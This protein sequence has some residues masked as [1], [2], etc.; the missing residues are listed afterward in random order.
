MNQRP[1]PQPS[2]P[3]GTR[4]LDVDISP[5]SV[6]LLSLLHDVTSARNSRGPHED[7]ATL[8]KEHHTVCFGL[9]VSVILLVRG[10]ASSIQQLQ[11]ARTVKVSFPACIH[12]QEK[13]HSSLKIPV[14]KCREA[15]LHHSTQ[16]LLYA[17]LV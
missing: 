12:I 6:A 4:T 8:M 9:G 17:C 7:N 1:R 14:E 5:D 16:I 10:P 15:S 13:L 11:L 2:Q 3:I